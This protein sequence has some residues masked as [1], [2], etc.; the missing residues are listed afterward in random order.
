MSIGEVLFSKRGYI[1]IPYFLLVLFLSKWDS[2]L[3]CIGLVISLFGEALRLWSVAYAGLTTRGREITAKTLVTSGPYG[4]VRNPIY[5]GNFLIGLGYTVALGVLRWEVLAIYFIGF[6]LEY[7]LIVRAE[8]S[9][10]EQKFGEEYRRYRASVPRFLPNFFRRYSS[11]Q[12][13]SPN[14]KMAFLSEKS[15]LL[16]LLGLY[17]LFFLRLSFFFQNPK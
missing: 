8:E 17:V 13:V 10:L 9:Y 16:L 2:R 14:F 6:F 7:Y 1:G 15:T 11:T 3:F 12:K 5:L 4:F